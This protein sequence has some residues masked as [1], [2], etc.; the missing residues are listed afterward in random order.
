MCA[1]GGVSQDA[2]SSQA[3]ALRRASRCAG[4]T[5]SEPGPRGI[6]G[7]RDRQAGSTANVCIS[8]PIPDFPGTLRGS[9]FNPKRRSQ[10]FPYSHFLHYFQN[11]AKT[12]TLTK[13]N[14]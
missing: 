9:I 10:L 2:R 4:H 7:S 5:S 14:P 6:P 12:E 3:R 11:V 13:F 8:A 1:G